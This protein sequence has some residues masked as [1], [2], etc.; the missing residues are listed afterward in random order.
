MTVVLRNPVGTRWSTRRGLST[1][2]GMYFQWDGDP[3]KV[4]VSRGEEENLDPPPNTHLLGCTYE[5]AA[6]TGSRSVHPFWQG[7]DTI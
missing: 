1:V 6:K 3:S 5:S 4:P 2:I 7:Y